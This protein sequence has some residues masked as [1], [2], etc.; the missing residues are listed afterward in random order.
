MTDAI[1]T[2][3]NTIVSGGSSL[4]AT[5]MK[6]KEPPHKTDRTT[7]KTHSLNPITLFSVFIF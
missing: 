2:L 7:I 1:E 4:T 6:K 3:H 5:S